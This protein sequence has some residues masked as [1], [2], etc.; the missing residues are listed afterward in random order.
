[1]CVFV[2]GLVFDIKRMTSGKGKVLNINKQLQQFSDLYV[3]IIRERSRCGNFSRYAK[4]H[5]NENIEC[6]LMEIKHVDWIN[7]QGLYIN[8]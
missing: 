4:Q 8:Q 7:E 3:P 1:M 2:L 6:L 5:Q